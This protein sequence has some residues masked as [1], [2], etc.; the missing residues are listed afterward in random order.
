MCDAELGMYENNKSNKGIICN[1]CNKE[2]NAE[3]KKNAKPYPKYYFLYMTTICSVIILFSILF[4][5][6][7]NT[8]FLK[9]VIPIF[10]ACFLILKRPLSTNDKMPDELDIKLAFGT[11]C[12]IIFIIV[13]VM[14]W[15][16]TL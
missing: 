15:I 5:I 1:K 16:H 7:K 12:L 2:V 9:L 14:L 6:T 3:I 8:T 11:M 10:P 13:V 4:V